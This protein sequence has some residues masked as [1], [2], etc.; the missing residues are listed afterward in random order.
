MGHPASYLKVPGGTGNLADFLIKS[1]AWVR[2][3][4]L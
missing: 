3:R 4:K 2:Y 1:I